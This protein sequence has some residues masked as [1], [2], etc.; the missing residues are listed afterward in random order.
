MKKEELICGS[1]CVKY[2]L[3]KLG[4]SNVK[5]QNNMIWTA[6]L[7]ISLK[8][9]GITDLNVYCFNSLLYDDFLLKKGEKFEGFKLLDDL[10]DMNISL[11][12]KKLN[13]W[14]LKKEIKNNAFIILCVESKK[15]NKNKNMSGGHFIILNGK[16][17]NK[18]KVINPMKEKYEI[19]YLPKRFLINCCKRYGSWRIV[20]KGGKND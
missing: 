5:I 17:D 4:L 18:V 9:N 19:K 15:F 16:K 10:I 12:S 20:I 2:V 8:Q 1:S 6:Q 14:E 13:M 7:A 11:M 3:G